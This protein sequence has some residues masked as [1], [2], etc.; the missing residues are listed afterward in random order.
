MRKQ[1]GYILLSAMAAVDVILRALPPCPA[2]LFHLLQY[3]F[4]LHRSSRVPQR[5]DWCDLTTQM[6]LVGLRKEQPLEILPL[7]PEWSLFAARCEV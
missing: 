4:P 5:R 3:G 6:D 2:S 7:L 1:G